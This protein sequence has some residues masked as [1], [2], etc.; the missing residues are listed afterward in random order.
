ME[1]RLV[2]P[3]LVRRFY[4]RMNQ[5]RKYFPGLSGQQYLQLSRLGDLY[6]AWNSR[7]NVISRKDIDNLYIHH[8]LYSLSIARI[9]SFSPSTR[10]MDAGTGGGFPGIPLAI[11]FPDCDFT[12][13]DSI[14]KKIRVV[15]EI[16]S[17]L[18]LK[19]VH[20]QRSRFEDLK[21]T[22]DFIVGRAISPI[23]EFCKILMGK[24][25]EKSKNT[26][27]NGIIY[28][29]GGD[30]LEELKGLPYKHHIYNIFEFFDDPFF[31][32]KKIIHLFL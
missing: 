23:P 14:A 11:L 17:E 9:V 3:C 29:K 28:L 15:E 10:I 20:P 6:A 18:G 26:L 25:S 13:V 5:V 7:I 30:F 2:G 32:T 12:L 22:W 16:T 1:D 31:E 8:V 4:L 19:N 21:E 27:P 24:V